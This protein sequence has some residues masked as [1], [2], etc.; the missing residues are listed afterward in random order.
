MTVPPRSS[1]SLINL[2][3]IEASRH[4]IARSGRFLHT[5]R[6]ISQ[7]GSPSFTRGVAIQRGETRHAFLNSG[8]AR[9]H[10][11]SIEYSGGK[12]GARSDAILSSIEAVAKRFLPARARSRGTVCVFAVELSI[13]DKTTLPREGQMC[14]RAR[15]TERDGVR[16]KERK[17]NAE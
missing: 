9:D 16:E 2:A 4:L 7:R 14:A 11:G 5:W 10:Y 1:G 6:L 13:I 15:R 8:N 12:P 17:A 3:A